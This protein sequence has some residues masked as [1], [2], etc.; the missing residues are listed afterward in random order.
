[1]SA[2]WRVMYQLTGKSFLVNTATANSSWLEQYIP[3]IDQHQ[4][5]AA[6][7]D[8]IR[9]KKPFEL[10]H[11]VHREDGTTG[12]TLSRAVPLLDKQGNITEW[13]GTA[14]DITQQKQAQQTDRQR[15]QQSAFMLRLTDMLRPLADP[16]AIQY[17][18]ARLLGEFLA[19]S[20]VGYAAAQDDEQLVAVTLHYTQG[21]ASIEGVYRY[22]DY[23]TLLLKELQAGNTVV[24]PNIAQDPTLSGAEKEAHAH[25]QLGATVNVPLRKQGRLAA[26]FFVHHQ[27]ARPWLAHEVIIIEETAERIWAAVERAKAEAALQDSERFVQGVIRSLPLVIYLFDLVHRRNRYLSPQVAQLFGYSP[28]QMQT[29]DRELIATFFHPD[30][31]LRL[32]AHFAHIRTQSPDAEDRS[33]F[34]TIDYRINHPQRGWVWVQSRDTVYARDAEGRPTLVLGTVEDISERIAAGR[35]VAESEK[36]L[37]LTI[38]ATQLATWEWDLATNQVFWN[39]QHFHLLGMAPQPNP[40]PAE[41]LFS[42]LHPDDAP[43]IQAQLQQTSQ[44]RVPYDAEFRIVREDGRIR[45][46]YGYGRVTAEGDEHPGQVSGVMLDI[47]ERKAT[48][49]AL[50]HSEQALAELRHLTLLSQTEALARTGSWEY[51]RAS[52]QFTWST[53]MYA[54]TEV[55]PQ[56]ILVP[57]I[58]L[59][60]AIEADQPQARSLIHYLRRGLGHFEGQLQ[61]QVRDTVKTLRIKG[62]VIG[63]GEATRVVGVDMDISEQ[64]LSQQRI[65]ETADSLQA[66]LDGSPASIGLL[67]AQR[68]EAGR[69]VDFRLAVG[70]DKLARFLGEPLPALLGQPAQRFNSLLWDGQTL[71]R[72]QRIF[73]TEESVY[74]EKQLAPPEQTTW[75]ALSVSRQDDGVVLTVLD[76]TALREAQAQQQHWLSELEGSR[77]S[78]E[79]LAQLKTALLHRSES[80]RA[81]SHDLK[82]NFGIINSSISLLELAESEA[83]REQFVSMA[84]RNVQQATGLLGELLDLTRLESSEQALRISSQNVSL[85]FTELGRNLSP[86]ADQQDLTL[87]LTGPAV[88]AVETDELLLYRLLQN[89][90]M[91]ALKYT[92]RGGVTLSWAQEPGSHQW[93]FTVADTGPGLATHLVERLNTPD[94]LQAGVGEVDPTRTIGSGEPTAR[95]SWA[96]LR[97]EGIGLRIVREI[98]HLLK[99][100]LEVS[101]AADQGTQF[102]VRLPLTYSPQPGTN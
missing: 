101:S 96:S 16:Q 77:H 45:W 47:T 51:H 37:R 24:R 83:E 48:Q 49:A 63:T 66:V 21:V 17:Q 44:Q 76:I 53:G 20:R 86:L 73:T 57:E 90:A 60:L 74:E 93:W 54:V 34:F 4:V 32:A 33:E 31:Q 64:L 78:V 25:L 92:H 52:G 94:P 68:D 1:M 71:D 2:D 41:T 42:H 58:Y 22:E 8:C 38:E 29:A 89:L 98:A 19:V 7:D 40:L 91:N 97:G 59:E 30:D 46:M 65:R 36:R 81:V 62:D 79:A 100:R 50:W 27:Q 39:E 28:Q 13:F 12:W 88:L 11:R 26:I 69:L 61:I 67:K 87:R 5:Q 102:R 70:N 55:D 3:A 82:S 43:A 99:A 84:L 56:R 6:I 15:D 14:R 23:G 72:L 9:A 95:E 10:E 85:L 75:I 18:A 80:L 35:A